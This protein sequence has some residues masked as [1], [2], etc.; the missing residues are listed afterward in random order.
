LLEPSAGDG[1]F[2]RGIAAD[3]SLARR[4]TA[5]LAIEP[6]E[7]E[8]EKCRRSLAATPVDGDVLTVSAIDWG[9]EGRDGGFDAAIGNPPFVRYQFIS[10]RDKAQIGRLGESVGLSFAGVSNLWLPVLVA[11][12]SRLRDDGAFSFVV[13][14]ELLT[15]LSAAQLRSWVARDFRDLRIDLF[16]PGPSRGCCRRSRCSVGNSPSRRPRPPS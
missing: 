11:A 12:L 6:Q 7:L 1:A 2:V 16:A 3:S 13:P 14:T 9:L 4:T 5:L 15:G 10:A 8:A